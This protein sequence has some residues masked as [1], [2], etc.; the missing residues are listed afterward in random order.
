MSAGAIFDS[1][2][3]QSEYAFKHAIAKVRKLRIFDN[4]HVQ[5]HIHRIQPKNPFEAIRKTCDLLAFGVVGIVGPTTKE[6]A[7]AVRSVS[8]GKEILL[9]D[10]YPEFRDTY[11]T[12]LNLHPHPSN[13]LEAYMFVVD[14]WSWRSFTIF[15]EDERSLMRMSELLK[16]RN[17]EDYKVVIKQLD[18]DKTGN[19]R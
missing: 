14:A 15:Y 6:N 4:Y 16:L 8:D 7:D 9:L 5:E 1:A 18:K 17:N 3:P 13:L 2:S 11:G 10:V 12:N 19:Y